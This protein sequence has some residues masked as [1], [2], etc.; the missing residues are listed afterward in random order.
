MRVSTTGPSVVMGP[1]LGLGNSSFLPV[2]EVC[3][4]SGM[5]FR[6]P[7]SLKEVFVGVPITG[8][9]VVMGSS[10]RLRRPSSLPVEEAW[11]GQDRGFCSFGFALVSPLGV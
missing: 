10:L 3:A 11:E 8:F 6:A 1:S 9:S 7:E 4:S 5:G 2:E